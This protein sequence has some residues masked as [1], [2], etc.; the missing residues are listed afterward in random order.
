MKYCLVPS[1]EGLTNLPTQLTVL[2]DLK[3]KQANISEAHSSRLQAY[4]AYEQAK[5]AYEQAD[6]T[7]RQGT[8]IM[9]VSALILAHGS[10]AK[11]DSSPLWQSSSYDR[12]TIDIYI[13]VLTRNSSLYQPYHQS[14]GSMPESS[15]AEAWA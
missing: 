3:Q 1:F 8:I 13:D 10:D 4:L 12:S 11:I 2:L 7:S 15:M 5:L 14:S 6:E 9:L